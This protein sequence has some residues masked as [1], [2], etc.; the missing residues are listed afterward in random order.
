[1][2]HPELTIGRLARAAGINVETV[3][4]YQRLGLI[5]EPQKPREGFRR[6]PPETVDR[7]LFIRR[8]KNLGFTLKEIKELLELGDGHCADVRARAEEKRGQ[9]AA[10]IRDLKR[11]RKT[12]DELIAACL[13][14]RENAHCPIV[15][16]LASAQKNP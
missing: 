2:K 7:I 12:L 9:V 3:R 11:L 13:A 15:D 5:Q 14:G 4:Y 16:T 6:Y 8:A 1:M 10:Q